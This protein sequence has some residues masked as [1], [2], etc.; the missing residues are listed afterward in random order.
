VR[1]LPELVPANPLLIF[2]N[3]GHALAAQ[4]KMKEEISS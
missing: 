1:K 2:L 4:Q 3:N